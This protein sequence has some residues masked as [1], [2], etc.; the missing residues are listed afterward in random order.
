MTKTVFAGIIASLG[1]ITIASIIFL[2]VIAYAP[3]SHMAFV[4][5]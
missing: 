5:I 3:A 1:G 4:E 2:L